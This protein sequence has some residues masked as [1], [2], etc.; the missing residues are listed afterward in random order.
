MKRS[1]E[2]FLA[3]LKSQKTSSALSVK[4]RRY[5]RKRLEIQTE[6]TNSTPFVY[7]P[8][9]P[10]IIPAAAEPP[11]TGCTLWHRNCQYLEIKDLISAACSLGKY[12]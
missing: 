10:N 5:L 7:G 8:D 12:I 2:D 9:I 1:L 4:H 6:S 11:K 3:M